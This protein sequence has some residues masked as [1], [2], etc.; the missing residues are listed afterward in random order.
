MLIVNRPLRTVDG[1]FHFSKRIGHLDVS[2][3][4]LRLVRNERRR[5]RNDM[6][7]CGRQTSKPG[8]IWDRSN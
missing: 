3:P 8:V 7:A 4:T 6:S 5:I 1:Q 2:S